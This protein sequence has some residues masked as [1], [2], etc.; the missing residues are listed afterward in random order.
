MPGSGR[1]PPLHSC[2]DPKEGWQRTAT[3][4]PFR[5]PTQ[6]NPDKIPGGKTL[7]H[8]RFQLPAPLPAADSRMLQ[9]HKELRQICIASPSSYVCGTNIHKISESSRLCTW[10]A[11]FTHLCTGQTE[12]VE[13]IVEKFGKIWKKVEKSSYFCTTLR[14]ELK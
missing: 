11:Q 9:P 3:S 5:A 4:S 7:P 12:L 8:R 2:P 10:E 6:G 13:K 1:R 14:T